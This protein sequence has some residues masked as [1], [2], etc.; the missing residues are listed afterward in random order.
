MKTMKTIEVAQL[1]TISGGVTGRWLTHHPFAAAGFL[2][3]HPCREAAFAQNHPR[4]WGRI[5]RNQDRWGIG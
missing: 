5:E 3:N 4:A 2:A 1:S